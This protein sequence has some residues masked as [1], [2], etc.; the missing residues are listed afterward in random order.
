MQIQFKT[1]LI[2]FV[3]LSFSPHI[4]ANGSCNNENTAIPFS[5]SSS[6]FTIHDNGT[7]THSVTGLM[8]MRCIIGQTWQN[9][10]CIGV[11]S[12]FT[13]QQALTQSGTNYAEYSDW[14]LPNKNELASIVEQRCY[15]PSI[16]EAIFPD[17]PGSRFWSTTPNTTRSSS[18][19][20]NYGSLAWG[21]NF[22]YGYVG[23]DTEANGY[24][25]VR[26]VRARQ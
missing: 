10:S 14:R 6:D 21:V 4:L 8:W 11:P 5:T 24:G 26:L 16:N 13:W 18:P 15:N 12:V 19:Y 2:L 17:T 3:L 23:N 22:G 20:T 1:L 7:V 9:E 25:F